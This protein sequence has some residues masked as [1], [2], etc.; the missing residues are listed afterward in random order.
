MTKNIEF[1]CSGNMDRSP[2]AEAFAKK[3]IAQLGRGDLGFHFRSSGTLVNYYGGLPE[4][5]LVTIMKTSE[6]KLVREKLVDSVDLAILRDGDIGALRKL[7][8]KLKQQSIDNRKAIIQAKGLSRYLS[9]DRARVQTVANPNSQIIYTADS[10][11]LERVKG[12][13]SGSG[14][15]PRI[16]LLGEEDVPDPFLVNLDTYTNIAGLVERAVY[17]A[18]Q[19]I[20]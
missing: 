15:N 17:Q 2:L 8:A 10:E 16:E 9:P 5:D 11:N 20:L 18:M 6:P 3:Y 1:V 12:L 13:Y 7:I 4:A 19:R 14:F